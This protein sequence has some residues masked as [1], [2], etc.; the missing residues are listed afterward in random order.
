ML[1]GAVSRV[2]APVA[3]A[4]LAVVLLGA[5]SEAGSAGAEE[6]P[7]EEEIIAAGQDPD[8]SDFEREVFADGKVTRGEYES[9]V[10]RLVACG[11]ARGVTIGVIPAGDMYNYSIAGASERSDAV[12]TECSMGTTM[13]IESLYEQVVVNP[14][15]DDINKL[16][17]ECFVRSG[18]VDDYSA[19]EYRY[20]KEQSGLGGPGPDFPF[21]PEDP[22]RF[23]CEQNPSSH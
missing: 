6:N 2:T 19:N 13:D 4:V 18:L 5:C 1:L 8:A 10:D 12:M 9:A 23:E 17:A 3:V 22:R 11:E 21:D 20:V 15:R 7:Y 16:V 14:E